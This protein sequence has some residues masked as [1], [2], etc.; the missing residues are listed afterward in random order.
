[1]SS[2]ITLDRLAAANP[3]P[4]HGIDID[5]SKLVLAIQE[6][7]V[8]MSTSTERKATK[9]IPPLADSA[10]PKRKKG[11][12]VALAAFAVVMIV[13]IVTLLGSTSTES[14]PATTPTTAVPTPPQ[15]ETE[16]VAV[17]RT[18]EIEAFDYGYSGF[19]T[20]FAVGDT[21]ELVNTSDSEY[22][23][24][25]VI[26]VEDG[27]PV[28]TIED[29]VAL[30]PRYINEVLDSWGRRLH[31]APGTKADG[32]IRLQTPGTY[33]ALDWMPQNA[34]PDAMSRVFDTAVIESPF[35]VAGGPLG[36]QHGMIVEFEVGDS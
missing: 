30:E 13:G 3:A 10:P 21:L 32:Q 14:P 26:S 36:Y 25:I 16:A 2:K 15:P 33:I 19:D 22:H 1:M 28:K 7:S 12:I 27:Y 8:A 34:D 6:R 11:W 9:G 20:E 29:V 18:V 24:L 35:T 17:P 5:D 31:A 4:E 23:A